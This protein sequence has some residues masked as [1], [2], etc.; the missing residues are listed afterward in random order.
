MAGRLATGLT[1][2]VP[3]NRR[4]LLFQTLAFSLSAA[5]LSRH[6]VRAHDATPTA[7]TQYVSEQFGYQIVWS[8]EWTLVASNSKPGDYDMVQLEQ[9]DTIAYIVIPRRGD[10]PLSEIAGFMIDAPDTDALAF[11]P[12]MTANDA[13]GNPIESETADRA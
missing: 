5:S 1:N 9:G 8:G 4:R 13:N 10:T 12:G 6:A 3:L 2:G 11:V 7:E